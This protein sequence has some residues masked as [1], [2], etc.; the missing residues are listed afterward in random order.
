MSRC[1]ICKQDWAEHGN[2]YSRVDST[3]VDYYCSNCG[4]KRKPEEAEGD[5]RI[6]VIPDI[7]APFMHEDAIDFLKDIHR[8]YKCTSVVIMGDE[9][10][11]HYSSFHDSDPDGMS[12]NAELELAAQQLHRLASEF[13]VAKVCIG[14]H[15]AIPQRRAFNS[16]LS[17]RWVKSVKEV[18]IELGVPCEGWDYADS[19]TIDGV[20]FT[21]GTGRKA[22]QRMLQDGISVVQGHYHS[23]SYIIHHVNAVQKNFAMQL[24]ALIDDDSY[25]MSYAKHFAK[26]HKNCGVI[27]DGVPIIE[28]MD[29][30]SKV[31]L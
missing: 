2:A 10:D 16:G 31:V 6:L 27:V 24:G 4:G 18:L 8:K 30:G 26:S 21:H 22:K 9:L 17:N 5:S 28:Y 15:T 29:L 1:P 12:A 7:H 25:A 20:K 14:N 23:E 13:P 11:N 19:W 3:K